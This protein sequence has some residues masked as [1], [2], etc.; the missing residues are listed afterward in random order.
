MH[1]QRFPGNLIVF[2]ETPH[3]GNE[4]ALTEVNS[5]AQGGG[6]DYIQKVLMYFFKTSL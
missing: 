5:Q 1:K 6:K 3:P 4:A 2:I